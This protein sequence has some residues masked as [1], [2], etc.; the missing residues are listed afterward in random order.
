M[1]RKPNYPMAGI[2]VT[3][4]AGDTVSEGINLN[5][6]IDAY[7]NLLRLFALIPPAEGMTGTTFTFQSSYDEGATW[8]DIHNAE[9]EYVYT[10]VANVDREVDYQ[11]FSSIPMFR[12][13]SGTSAAPVEQVA[14]CVFTAILRVV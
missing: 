9:A 1:I 4:L 3:I 10:A 11:R 8:K 7:A 5:Q 14:N 13:R 2:P 12:I 6:Y